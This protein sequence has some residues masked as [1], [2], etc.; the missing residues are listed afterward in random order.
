MRSKDICKKDWIIGEGWFRLRALIC[1]RARQSFGQ[2][3]FV[4]FSIA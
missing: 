2:S 4:R 1:F 3:F